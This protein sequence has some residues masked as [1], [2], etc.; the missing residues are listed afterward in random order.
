MPFVHVELAR[1]RTPGQLDAMAVAV[2]DAVQHTLGAPRD[3][4]RVL[5]TQCEPQ[6]WFTGGRSLADRTPP[7]SPGPASKTVGSKVQLPGE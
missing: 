7:A 4:V 6:H 2:T 5:I 3:S 1:G